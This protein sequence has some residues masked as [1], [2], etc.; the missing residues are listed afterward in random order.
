MN[1][2]VSFLT[3]SRNSF[4]RDNE[5]IMFGNMTTNYSP[6]NLIFNSQVLNDN[7]NDLYNLLV[8]HLNSSYHDG[9]LLYYNFKQFCL[10]AT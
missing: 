9:G 10:I 8:V 7:N 1:D 3:A 5:S 4:I 2:A 6:Y